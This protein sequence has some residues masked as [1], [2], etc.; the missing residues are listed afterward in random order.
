MQKEKQKED[1]VNEFREQVEHQRKKFSD[2]N[3]KNKMRREKQPILGNK[4]TH[5]KC[6]IKTGKA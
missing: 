2:K 6:G 4:L 1:N 5:L 3:I